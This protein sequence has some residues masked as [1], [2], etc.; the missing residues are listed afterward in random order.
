MGKLIK[1]EIINLDPEHMDAI[2]SKDFVSRGWAHYSRG[3]YEKAIMDFTI[4]LE[5]EINVDYYYALGLALKENGNFT[6]AIEKFE[7]G[8][9]LL[10][11]LED[12]TRAHML[13]R[14]SDGQINLIKEG[15][16]NLEKE[17]WH[18]V[19]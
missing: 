13:K 11:K 17:I 12:Q 4:A 9:K 19:Q 10:V 5:K 15:D 7:C 6:L 2:E 16:W 14:L 8:L 3:N 1:E 18:T